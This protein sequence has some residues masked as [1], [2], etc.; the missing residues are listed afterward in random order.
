MSAVTSPVVAPEP[1]AELPAKT[2]IGN[3]VIDRKIAAGGMA[4]V[5]AASHAVLPRR[6]ALKVMHATML[7]HPGAA[8]RMLIEATVLARVDH[9]GS[10]EVYDCGTLPDGR[11]WIAMELLGDLPLS[12]VLAAKG[13]LPVAEVL[14]LMRAIAT[15]LRAAHAR[16]IV[17]RDLKPEN[18]L[19][20]G[21]AEARAY[22]VIDWGIAHQQACPR[23]TQQE[24]TLG[25]PTY[26]APE[27]ARGDAL[28]GRCDVYALGVLA[29]EA[30]TGGPPFQASSSIAT[31]VEH[32]TRRPTPLPHLRADVP[33]AVAALIHTMLAKDPERRP[34]AAQVCERIDAF[35]PDDLTA[36]AP[37]ETWQDA[38]NHLSTWPDGVATAPMLAAGSGPAPARAPR[39]ARG[40][41]P[42]GPVAVERRR[43]V[44]QPRIEAVLVPR[45]T[46]D[47]PPP[48]EDPLDDDDNVF[49]DD[50]ELSDLRLLAIAAAS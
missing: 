27:Q 2:K 37:A 49:V 36:T 4:T 12:S 16:G 8:Q 20:Q 18:V 24:T 47:A 19:V 7:V 35:T 15:T 22:R 41:A 21:P 33:D 10:V 29:Y 3:Y 5:Y 43:R 14:P 9:P 39:L 26:M 45:E 46:D 23:V 32:L 25:T 44:H 42:P 6:A 48:A 11:A 1:H 40:S 13:P 38:H 28:D 50:I 17:H 34:T 31:L 30:L